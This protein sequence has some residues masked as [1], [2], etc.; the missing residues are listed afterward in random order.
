M[1]CPN[2]EGMKQCNCSDTPKNYSIQFNAVLK[3]ET[4]TCHCPKCNNQCSC[5][6]KYEEKI[7]DKH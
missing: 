7:N 1:L 5:V 2:G 4:R 3:Q 6:K